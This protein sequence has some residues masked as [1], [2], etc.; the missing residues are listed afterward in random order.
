[1]LKN[2]ANCEHSCCRECYWWCGITGRE[3]KH[4]YLMG[5]PKKCECWEKYKR[6]EDSFE[7]PTRDRLK[8]EDD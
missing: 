3:L 1:M 4:P 8:R 6:E 2:C 5:G 7:Y